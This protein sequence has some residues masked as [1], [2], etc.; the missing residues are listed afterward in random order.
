MNDIINKII[1]WVKANLW[2]SL[3][4]LGAVV[5]FLFPKVFKFPFSRNIRRRRNRIVN[6]SVT[7]R[8]RRRVIPRSVGIRRKRKSYTTGG[9]RKKPWQIKGSLAARRH[10]AQIR[11]MK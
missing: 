10:M 5:L 3:G 6:R 8:R 1:A 9:K 7:R 4:I 11:R 2:L